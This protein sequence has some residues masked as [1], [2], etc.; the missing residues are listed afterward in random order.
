MPA[1]HPV[2]VKSAG[3]TKEHVKMHKQWATLAR[4]LQVERYA[5]RR[6]YAAWRSRNKLGEG[7]ATK[8]FNAAERA[9]RL[10]RITVVSQRQMF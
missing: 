9:A 7:P 8:W 5:M 4:L 1:A 2:T 3:E 10:S 6:Y